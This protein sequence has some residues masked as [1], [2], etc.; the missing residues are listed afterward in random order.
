LHIALKPTSEADSRLP[1]SKLLKAQDLEELCTADE[2]LLRRAILD[3]PPDGPDT[4]V[5]LIPDGATMMWH[6]AREEFLAQEVLNATPEAKGAVVETSDGKRVWCLWTR[7]FAK[8]EKENTL[9]I[10]RLVVEGDYS[11]NENTAKDALHEE[12]VL[13][14]AACFNAAQREAT[15]WSMRSVEFWNPSSIAIE[16]AMVICPSAKVVQRETESIPCLNW[17]DDDT[18]VE[19]V[20]NE[21]FGWC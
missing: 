15:K 21:K 19:W 18:N 5:A 8:D 20:I 2:A 16:G 17:Y 3:F 10:L 12:R 13:A 4:R 14:V 11:L 9:F 6:H 1:E 7:T